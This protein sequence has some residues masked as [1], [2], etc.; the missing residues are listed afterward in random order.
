MRDTVLLHEIAHHLADGHGHGPAFRAALVRLYRV[1]VHPGAAHMLSRGF[2]H[3]E[4]LPDPDVR[5]AQ[6]GDDQLRRVA[7]LLAKAESTTHPEEAEAYLARAA[8]V[9]Q[10]HSIDLAVAAM[11]TTRGP[12]TPTRRM[13]SIG[14]PRRPVNGRFVSLLLAVARAWGVRADIGPSSTYV[15]VYGMP[16]DLDQVESVY[17]T[18]ATMMVSHAA[19]HLREGRW[20]GTSYWSTGGERRP[21]TATVARNAFCLGFT[22][23]LGQRL[24]E[25]QA[26]A[27]R[28]AAHEDGPGAGPEPGPVASDAPSAGTRST[29]EGPNHPT[30]QDIDLALRRREAA[31]SEYHQLTTRAKGSWR[32]ASGGS[33]SAAGSRAAGRQAAE[34][35]GARALGAGGRALP[36]GTRS[37]DPGG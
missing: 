10:R 2:E 23:R 37:S 21:V 6:G 24:A 18:A 22:E 20:R 32:G 16:G 27:R 34:S 30:G 14:E 19:A 12:E 13:I 4:G 5:P 25:A 1:H 29:P 7:A 3:L 28:Q 15:I 33:W 36:G 35:Y 26:T 11:S 8:I 31:V 9:A 17:A